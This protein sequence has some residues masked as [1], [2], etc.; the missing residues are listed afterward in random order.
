MQAHDTSLTTRQTAR[1][2]YQTGGLRALFRGITAIVA[3]AGMHS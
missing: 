2:I 3:S 1:M